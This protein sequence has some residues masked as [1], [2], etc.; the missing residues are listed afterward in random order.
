M[1]T[2]YFVVPAGID[3]TAHPSGGNVYDRRIWR[4]LGGLGWSVAL[5]PVPGA[6]P[7]PALAACAAL[8][9]VVSAIPDG[10]VVLV[11]GL[12]ASASPRVL[13][14]H[15]RR[16]R[17]V[18]LVHMPLAEAWTDPERAEAVRAEEVRRSEGAVLGAAAAVI[19]T[20]TWS[21][22]RLLGRYPLAPDAVQVAEPGVDAA[23]PAVGTV[24]GT[25]MICVA[26]VSAHKGHDVLVAALGRIADLGWHCVCIGAIDGDPAF[27]DGLRRQVRAAGLTD[28]IRLAGPLTGV[29]LD[30]AY[31]AADALLL[32]SR[33]ETYGM[34]VTEALAREIPV[35][36]TDV[37]GIADTVGFGFDGQRPGLLVPAGD[38]VALAAALRSWLGD[39]G[40]RRRL[41]SAARHR[42]ETLTGW[43]VTS[44]R[45]SRVLAA[46]AT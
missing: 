27:V 19:A 21:R 32:A 46:V 11:D 10:A 30:S 45:I 18:V 36:A 17:L 23:E 12:V 43:P 1:T 24:R 14:P 4:G 28:R 34:V 6:W 15:A 16:L 2:V 26:Q 31:A 40:L 22:C 29:D 35:I 25:E 7:R 8:E 38:S 41:R 42:R 5:R 39:A 3:D 33:A 9:G 37:G 13:M 44:D 20:S